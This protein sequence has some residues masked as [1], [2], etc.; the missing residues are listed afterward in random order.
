MGPPICAGVIG[1]LFEVT[2]ADET[3]WQYVNPMVRGGILA[4]G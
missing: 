4:Q 1:N 2:P 3:A